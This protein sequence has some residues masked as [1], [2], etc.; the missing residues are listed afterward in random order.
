LQGGIWLVVRL[1]LGMEGMLLAGYCSSSVPDLDFGDGGILFRQPIVIPS[2]WSKFISTTTQ[3]IHS[4]NPRYL[5]YSETL[6]G[7]ACLCDWVI[8]LGCKE[9]I[10]SQTVARIDQSTASI[11]HIRP[12]VYPS[13]TAAITAHSSTPPTTP[14]RTQCPLKSR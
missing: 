9:V 11:S 12:K 13:Q 4:S 3:S 14:L 1:F 7:R 5:K 8:V 2:S 6:A 10:R